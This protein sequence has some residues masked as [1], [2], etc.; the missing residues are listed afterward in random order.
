M[1]IE[2]YKKLQIPEDSA[3]GRKTIRKYLPI[4]LKEIL[5]GI[6]NIFIWIP[7]LYK[8]KNWD[9]NYIFEIL[10]FKLIQQRNYLVKANRHTSVPILNKDITLCL[11]L[12][13][14]IKEDYY[15]LEYMDYH[16]SNYN[17]NPSK[18]HPDYKELDIVPVWEKYDDYFNKHKCSFK[19]VLKENEDLSSNKDRLAMKLADF[20]QRRCQKILFEKLNSKINHWWD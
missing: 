8:D 3:W 17:W 10:K 15:G 4:W 16:E 5:D 6:K 7:T 9:D 19:K 1:E 20:N 13:E 2:Q 14:R 11:N 12:I 18:E